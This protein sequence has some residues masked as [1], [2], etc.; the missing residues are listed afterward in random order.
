[1]ELRRSLAHTEVNTNL[2]YRLHTFS[3]F[4]S[5]HS[6]FFLTAPHDGVGEPGHSA[7][8]A[9]PGASQRLV[10]GVRA[11]DGAWSIHQRSQAESHTPEKKEFSSQAQVNAESLAEEA[12]GGR[13]ER[14]EGQRGAL[15]EDLEPGTPGELKGRAR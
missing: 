3:A 5:W 6:C 13:R 14:G 7:R 4:S 10:T 8:P 12:G 9:E 11:A 1:M 2:L 15:E